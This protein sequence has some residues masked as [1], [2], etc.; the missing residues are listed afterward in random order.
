MTRNVSVRT[1]FFGMDGEGIFGGDDAPAVSEYFNYEVELENGSPLHQFPKAELRWGGE[2][3]C[4][5]YL[6]VE[7]LDTE[8]VKLYG[9]GILFVGK[10]ESIDDLSGRIDFNFVVPTRESIEKKYTVNNANKGDDYA[11][12]TVECTNL[13]KE[14]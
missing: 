14:I 4:E 10:S 11:D 13:S 7:A 8:N 3:R 9:T 5:L 1:R 12:I 2:C 6:S